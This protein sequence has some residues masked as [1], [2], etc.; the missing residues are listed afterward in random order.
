M[1]KW[2]KLR[3]RLRIRQATTKKLSDSERYRKTIDDINTGKTPK[4]RLHAVGE[5][6]LYS[7]KR[8]RGRRGL[9]PGGKAEGKT[10]SDIARKHGISAAAA[11]AA[12]RRGTRIEKEHTTNAAVAREIA[13]DHVYENPR[14]YD[15]IAKIE[16]RH[17]GRKKKEDDKEKEDVKEEAPVNNVGGGKIAGTSPGE[18]PP[19]KSYLDLRKKAGK[20]RLYRR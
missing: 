19:I 15:M 6:L 17:R 20:K 5:S 4:V 13:K 12:I 8:R 3:D 18:Q 16:G 2:K 10:V 1:S 7:K 14:Y 9:I 11:E